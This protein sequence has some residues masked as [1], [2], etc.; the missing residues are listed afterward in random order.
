M[1]LV[2][3]AAPFAAFREFT[4]GFNRPS[5]PYPPPSAIYGLLLNIA[6]IESRGEAPKGPTLTREELPRLRL[7]SALRRPDPGLHSFA[8]Q[9][10]N[11]RRPQPG[12]L[13]QHQHTVPVGETSKERK[14]LTKGNKHHISLASRGILN[15]LRGVC[16]VEAETALEERIA[17]QLLSPSAQLDNGKTRYG[18]P[19]LGDNNLFLEQLEHLI[20]PEEEEVDWL[21]HDPHGTHLTISIDREGMAR[22]RSSPFS[23][24]A[25]SL[26]SPPPL[27]WVELGG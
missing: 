6:G 1:I 24:L 10:G 21:V 20:N 3:Y 2:A 5:L 9:L 4:A 14:P 16:V 26:A 22:T 11:R 27:A 8:E 18:L 13:F 15:G 12:K 23:L 7:A 19:F 25:A 17:R